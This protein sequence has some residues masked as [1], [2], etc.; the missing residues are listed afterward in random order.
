VSY[1]FNLNL[2]GIAFGLGFVVGMLLSMVV[3]SVVGSGV[4]AVIVCYAEDPA[5]FEINHYTLSMRMRESW[6][7]AFPNDF[8]Y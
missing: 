7:S 2:E 5:T 4:N 1:L 8:T 6:R 3:L